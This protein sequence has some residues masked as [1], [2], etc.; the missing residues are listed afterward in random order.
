L[1]A[2]ATQHPAEE[3]ARS[4]TWRESGRHRGAAY[5]GRPLPDSEP[6]AAA[7]VRNYVTAGKL[8]SGL[9]RPTCPRRPG[10]VNPHPLGDLIQ[11]RICDTSMKLPSLVP[12]SNLLEQ[13]E[14]IEAGL[15]KIQKIAGTPVSR[16]AKLAT[17]WDRSA[18]HMLNL[19]ILGSAQMAKINL[20]SM[21]VDALL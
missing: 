21:S 17:L 14:G 5:A 1:I 7:E 13:V 15:Q 18:P 9:E 16:P 20:A 4:M 6:A 11:L 3:D 12:A 8:L 10:G 2:R 19:L